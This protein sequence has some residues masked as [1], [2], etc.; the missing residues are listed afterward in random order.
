[1]VVHASPPVVLVVGSSVAEGV[2]ARNDY[3]WASM[4]GDALS[5]K[6]GYVYVNE[7]VSGFTTVATAALLP[8]VLRQHRPSAVVI[9]LSLANEGLPLTTSARQAASLAAGYEQRLLGMAATAAAFD[10]V[11]LVML[12]GV[13]PSNDYNTFQYAEL[14]ASNARLQGD[15]ASPWPCVPSATATATCGAACTYPVIDFLAVTDDGSGAWKAGTSVDS[16]HPNDAGHKAMFSA[17]DLGLF[18]GLA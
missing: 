2:G 7:A 5:E 3:G 14:L 10:G 1:M 9:A 12:G 11:K 16:G 17:V 13:Y 6:Y 4:M 15:T 8:S 18:S